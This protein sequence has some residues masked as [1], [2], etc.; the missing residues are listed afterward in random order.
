MDVFAVVEAAAL[1]DWLD[2]LPH[3][4]SA[5]A[6]RMRRLSTAPAA[7]RLLVVV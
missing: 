4:D 7:L 1:A 6:I 3:A 5:T 2:E